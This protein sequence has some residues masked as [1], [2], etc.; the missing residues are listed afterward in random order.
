M[1]KKTT[2][3]FII[4]ILTI[5]IILI[6]TISK[7]TVE[8]KPGGTVHTSISVS[9]SYQICYEMR[10][11][12][13]GNNSLDPHLTTNADWAA[14]AYLGLSAYGSVRSKDGTS[15]SIEET[16]YYST[17]NN[18][19][20]IMNMGVKLTQTASL[21]T[22]YTTSSYR[23]NLEQN[24]NTKYVETLGEK[25]NDIINKGKAIYELQRMVRPNSILHSWRRISSIIKNWSFRP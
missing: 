13:L 20:G 24:I 16:N 9:D 11:D 6:G 23:T 15:V 3:I 18:I 12:A 10:N 22:G 2:K 7:A 19:T 25:Y 21:R 4:I 1:N 5:T 8:N 14:A 17:T